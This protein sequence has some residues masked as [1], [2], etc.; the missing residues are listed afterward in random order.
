MNVIV[1]Q[2]RLHQN[3]YIFEDITVANIWAC[4]AL[5]FIAA[6]PK[7]ILV[8]M[9]WIGLSCAMCIPFQ[10]P[11]LHPVRTWFQIL[12]VVE[13]AIRPL[14]FCSS[15]LPLLNSSAETLHFAFV[16]KYFFVNF[17]F[18][19]VSYS[20]AFQGQSSSNQRE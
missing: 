1:L 12:L 14:I 10:R 6:S 20:C 13:Q 2:S 5:I 15:A 3:K 7:V 9:H 11:W 18:L 4:F 17:N 8:G 19:I 16:I